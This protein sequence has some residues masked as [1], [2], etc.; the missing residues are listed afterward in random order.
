MLL[1]QTIKAIESLKI[2]GA[3]NVAIAALKA[4]N[5]VALRSKAK[6]AKQFYDELFK[7]RA[8]LQETRPTEP[9]M[10]NALKYAFLNANFIDLRKSREHVL[11]S[12]QNAMNHI[13]SGKQHITMFGARKVF[14]NSVI[15]THCHS[16]TVISILKEA[17][18]EGKRFEVHNTETRPLYQGRK[19]A[20]ELAASGIKVVHYV[21][22]AARLAL[23]KSDLMLLGAD[24]ITAEGKVINKIGSELFA[25]VAQK[26]GIPVYVC[27]DSWKFD[28]KTMFGFDE[29][30]EIRGTK[31]IWKNPPKGVAIDSHAFEI[32][33]SELIAGIIT[34]FGIFSPSTLIL[35][36]KKEHPWMFEE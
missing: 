33:S 36:L 22:S 23:K 32:I 8:L 31:E 9:L 2:Q 26:Y 16:S 5:Y 27:A 25:E 35:E 6:T 18:R 30:I 15:F 20:I 14:N 21:D 7:S 17:K 29:P 19:T 10:R 4:L 11:M 24:A 13:S 3:E 28:A 12:I 34:E 1:K